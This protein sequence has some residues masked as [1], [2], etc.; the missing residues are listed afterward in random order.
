MAGL[1]VSHLTSWLS[2]V[3]VWS[4]ASTLTLADGVTK[5]QVAFVAALLYIIS[6]AGIF[7]SAP[8]TESLF[9]SSHLLGYF[10]FISGRGHFERQKTGLAAA[11]TIGAGA[12]FG[13]ATAVRSNGILSG[14]LFAWDA[15]AS[16]VAFPQSG[17]RRLQLLRLSSLV[18]G[19]LLIFVGMVLPQYKAFLEYCS[20]D[21]ADTARPWC[22]NTVPS[23][24]TFVQS[25]YW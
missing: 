23:I 11:C 6:P 13:L 18:V 4:I 1:V 7:L 21:R 5:S 2:M 9:A 25:Y 14:M 16:G 12:A 8:Y 10:L 17:F 22:N 20:S 3:L 19:G 15:V 24:F